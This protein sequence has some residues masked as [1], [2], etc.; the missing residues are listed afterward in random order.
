MK[1]VKKLSDISG[2]TFFAHCPSCKEYFEDDIP[3]ACAVFCPNGCG[4]VVERGIKPSGIKIK[5]TR[6]KRGLS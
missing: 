4:M 3:I 2:R 5:L 1:I 6:W